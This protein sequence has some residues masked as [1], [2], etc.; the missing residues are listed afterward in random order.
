MDLNGIRPDNHRLII[1]EGN[2]DEYF[3]DLLCHRDQGCDCI[4]SWIF[5]AK[6]EMS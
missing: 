1:E 6:Q 4:S 5:S 2:V 3:M